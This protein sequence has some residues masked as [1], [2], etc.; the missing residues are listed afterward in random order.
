MSFHPAGSRV[1]R[2]RMWA[3]ALGVGIVGALIIGIYAASTAGNTVEDSRAGIGQGTVTGYDV[4][5]VH[6]TLDNTDPSL[7]IAVSFSLDEEPAG[8][9]TVR[10]K[11]SNASTTWYSCSWTGTAVTCPTTSPA[12]TVAQVSELVVVAA[13]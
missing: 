3:V 11:L 8:G 7:V 5:S 13:Q 10:I 9:S 2:G 6:Y 1:R 4:T 12:A